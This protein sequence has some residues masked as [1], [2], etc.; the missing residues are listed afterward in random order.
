M[1]GIRTSDAPSGH[2]GRIWYTTQGFTLGCRVVPLRGWAA[3]G[4]RCT[5]LKRVS[6][7][8]F[9][10]Q[11]V[12]SLARRVSMK[13]TTPAPRNGRAHLVLSGR[14]FAI[15]Q[16]TG[17]ASDISKAAQIVS[18]T[19]RL[20]ALRSAYCCSIHAYVF[21]MPSRSGMS[22]SQ[23]SVSLIMVLSLLRPATPRGA[24]SL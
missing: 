12:S 23:S 10:P 11:P 14:V 9:G 3:S 7:E 20:P 2:G 15:T 22:G 21:A 24:S 5:T 16:K 6:A 13:T 8:E 18:L 19:V 1:C 17:L 4:A